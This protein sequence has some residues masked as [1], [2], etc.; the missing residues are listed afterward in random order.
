MQAVIDT[1]VVML[2]VINDILFEE[3]ENRPSLIDTGQALSELHKRILPTV[4]FEMQAVLTLEELAKWSERL[5]EAPIYALMAL[6]AWTSDV[7]DQT[8]LNPA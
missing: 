6:H 2:D 5:Q 1:E 3:L 8:E 7:L 4:D